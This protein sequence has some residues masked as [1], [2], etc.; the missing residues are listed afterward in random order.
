MVGKAGLGQGFSTYLI[1]TFQLSF[2]HMRGEAFLAVK[3]QI[4]IFW[5]VIM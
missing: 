2:H 1:F 3:V 4:V 5:V